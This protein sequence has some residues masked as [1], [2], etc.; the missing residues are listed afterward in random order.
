MRARDLLS[1][2]DMADVGSQ[3][4]EGAAADDPSGAAVA[5]QVHAHHREGVLQAPRHL[6]PRPEVGADAM[7]ER[8]VGT[9]PGN[10]EMDGGPIAER[11][12]IRYGHG[13]FPYFGL[14]TRLDW[15]D[16]SEF[17]S[18]LMISTVTCGLSAT[19]RHSAS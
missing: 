14:S 11:G 8:D 3:V 18:C 16:A 17:V 2:P 9:A 10:D 6:V 4:V 15:T 12:L 7:D 5:A 19:A 13:A 1:V